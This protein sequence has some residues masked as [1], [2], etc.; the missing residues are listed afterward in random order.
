MLRVAAN[1]VG[2]GIH[3]ISQLVKL[4]NQNPLRGYDHRSPLEVIELG[5]VEQLMLEQQG[6]T[7]NSIPP[8]GTKIELRRNSNIS[9]GGDSIDVTN[10]MDPTYKQLAAE[11]AEAMGAWVCG[12]D[13][14]IPNATQAYS[15]D[16]KN[17]TCIELNFN[18]LMYMH[19]YCQEGPGQSITPRILAKLF[20][21][22]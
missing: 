19:T 15:K 16:K 9:T 5:E 1:V 6:Y 14:I 20:P 18:P 11:M 13:L 8:E 22:L 2:D 21:E 7:V 17:A 10:T 12:V 4:K 3:T